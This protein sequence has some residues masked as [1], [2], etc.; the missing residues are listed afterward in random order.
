MTALPLVAT[1]GVT[2]M[3]ATAV[4][5]VGSANPQG[6]TGTCWFVWGT[7]TLFG[8]VTPTQTLAA[9]GFPQTFQAS[10][11]NLTTGT[12]YYFA[13]VG[14][15]GEGTVVS[16]PLS[17]TPVAVTTYASAPTIPSATPQV[18]IPHFSYPFT[19]T[20]GGALVVDQDSYGE[21]LSCVQTILACPLAACPELPKFGYPDPTFSGAP[22]NPAAIVAAIKGLEPRATESVIVTALD[23]IGAGWNMA[24]STQVSGTGE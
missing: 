17:F 10:L 4:N 9:T 22:P 21:V 20:N 13:A 7:S 8:S 12:T 5:L 18:P 24:I 16:A 11:S 14:E 15:N 3:T 23:Q 6:V 1:V 19:L 2:G